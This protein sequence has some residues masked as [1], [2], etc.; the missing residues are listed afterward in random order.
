[1]DDQQ[2]T[3]GSPGTTGNRRTIFEFGDIGN[4]T[5]LNFGFV[6]IRDTYMTIYMGDTAT[7]PSSAFAPQQHQWHHLVL[8]Y[9]GSGT[10]RIFIDNTEYT[11]SLAGVVNGT[12]AIQVNADLLLGS[13]GRLN[14]AKFRGDISNFKVYS[15]ALE[16]SE[17]KKLY[18]LGR[19]GRSMVISD[20]A[21]GIGKVPEAQLDVRG[22]ISCDG[23][24]KPYTCA[25]SAYVSSGG[26]S[27]AT[28]K[29]P[30]ESVHF[31]IGNCYN[32]STYEFTAPVH[33][34]YHMSFSAF[35]NTGATSSSRIYALING[36]IVEQVG[37]TIEQHGNSLSLTVEM[38]AG[39][40]F[41]L[42]GGAGVPIYYFGA[43]GHNRF[44]GHLICAL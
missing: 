23:I 4:R 13:E 5:G 31:N 42:T 19:T 30:A 9:S 24:L 34:I 43:N 10:L 27:S 21:V 28:G 37:A 41:A 22:N 8:M 11:S 3:L 25:F 44:S 20:T 26:N 35:T 33:G 2:S 1:M 38:Q 16:P 18:N 14:A 39:E 36:S 17:V 40:T 6:D 29:F 12:L 32:T 15:V 7:L